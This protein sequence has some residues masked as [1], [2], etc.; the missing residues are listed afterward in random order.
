M[1]ALTQQQRQMTLAALLR[2]VMPDQPPGGR[3]DGIVVRGLSQDSRCVRPGDVFL[4]LRGGRHDAREY[5]DGAIASGAVAV[6]ADAGLADSGKGANS[7]LRW[8][9]AVPVISVGQLRR[10]VGELASR[11]FGSPS[12]RLP[13][14]GVTGTNGKTSLTQYVAQILEGL[15]RRCGVIGTLGSGMFPALRDTGYT[16]PDAVAVHGGL[17]DLADTGADCVAME[18]SSQGLDQYRVTGVTFYSAV[19]TNLTRDHLDY[20]G[21]MTAYASA[22]QK[23]FETAQLHAAVINADDP[24]AAAM[25]S[26]LPDGARS[27]TYS[28]E[29]AADVYV[30]EL[31]LHAGGFSATV[32]SP[33]GVASVESSLLGIFNL[34]NVLAALAA[35][36]TLPQAQDF[37]HVASQVQRL[38]PV[39]GRMQRVSGGDDLTVVIDYAH[40]PDGLVSALRAMRDHTQGRLWCVFGCGGERDR[41][42][43]PLMAQAAQQ[44]ADFVVVTDDNPRFEDADQIVSEILQ[45]FSEPS[46]E[47]VIVERHRSEAIARTILMAEPGDSILIAGKGHETYQDVAGKRLPFSDA[48]QAAAALAHREAQCAQGGES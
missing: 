4:A 37:H 47:R 19:F 33:W 30:S 20:H 18:V 36:M 11:F 27:I 6:L 17:A 1:T 7:E 38:R 32:H 46:G 45:G 35:V 12:S 29:G 9:A 40:T 26:A 31:Q 44:W 8:M 43:R 21:S 13:V 15:G 24:Y 14:I 3:L 39:A 16:T 28:V 42:K 22:K 34:S 10:R 41:G 5:I 25:I 23:L 2:E 48:E